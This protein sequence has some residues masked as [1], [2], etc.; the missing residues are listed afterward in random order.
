[1]TI[2]PALLDQYRALA[3]R[4]TPENVEHNPLT[5]H[6]T[7][8]FAVLACATTL[9]EA[10]CWLLGTLINDLHPVPHTRPFHPHLQP[11]DP[12][13]SQPTRIAH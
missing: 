4:T 10:R 8:K 1:M 3:A 9:H 6:Y 2:P 5:I 7:S 12:P 11:I 13:N